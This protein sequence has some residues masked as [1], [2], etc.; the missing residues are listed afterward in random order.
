MGSEEGRLAT[1]LNLMS[2]AIRE[3]SFWV[4]CFVDDVPSLV[5][6]DSEIFDF[7][8]FRINYAHQ[9]VWAL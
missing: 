4:D 3:P 5:L 6:A 9:F 1:L 2:Y 8:G 7:N